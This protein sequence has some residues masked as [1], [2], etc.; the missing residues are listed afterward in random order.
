MKAALAPTKRKDVIAP[1]I[2]KTSM[3]RMADWSVPL[4]SGGVIR[5]LLMPP[6]P[7]PPRPPQYSLPLN[8]PS[9][10]ELHLATVGRGDFSAS[11]GP[12]YASY[13]IISSR[14]SRCSERGGAGAREGC[15]EL[16]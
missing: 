9:S 8:K 13:I 5:L 4:A 14:P 7:V 2:R 11:R 1:I 10:S 15:V 16:I 12:N 6:L 3:M